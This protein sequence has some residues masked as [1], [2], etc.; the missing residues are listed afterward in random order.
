MDIEVRKASGNDHSI[1]VDIGR[2]AVYEAHRASCSEADMNQY[3]TTHYNETAITNELNDS[4]NIYHLLFYRGQPAGFSKIVV[5]APHAGIA[6]Q[7]VTKL[8]RI[9]LL[10]E[11]HGLKLGAHLLNHNIALSQE[12]GQYGMW[13][14]TWVGNERAVSF[15]KK[16]GFSVIGTH[17]F[18]VSDTHYNPN[19]HMFLAYGNAS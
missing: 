14:F 12:N 4:A 5:N 2:I 19:H 10:K 15:Y 3:L 6:Q 17:Q 11:F 13:L 18:K 16:N 9:Y 8:D 1:I 7:N